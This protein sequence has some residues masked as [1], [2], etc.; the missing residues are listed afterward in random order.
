MFCISTIASLTELLA[1]ISTEFLYVDVKY[2]HQYFCWPAR[3][4]TKLLAARFLQSLL[5]LIAVLVSFAILLGRKRSSG[6]YSNPSSIATMASLL[7]HP[8]V[9]DDFHNLGPWASDNDVARLVHD[10]RYKLA[11]YEL[12][13]GRMKYGITVVEVPQKTTNERGSGISAEALETGVKSQSKLRG[14]GPVILQT[15]QDF[16]LTICLFGVLGVILA[17]FVN[18]APN[19]FE[20]FMDS[21]R[22]GPAFML[23]SAGGIIRAQWKRIEQGKTLLQ[24]P[25]FLWP[26]W[27][28]I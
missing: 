25:P 24:L 11:C 4:S 6:V 21:Q 2:C 3:L 22:F 20:R 17:Y 12:A 28:S 27:L 9:L 16:L 10:K 7:H 8:K 14:F 13:G 26:L 18:L 19:G 15:A 23:V 1:P 5:A